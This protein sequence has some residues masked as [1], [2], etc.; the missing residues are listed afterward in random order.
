KHFPP[1][2]YHNPN[3]DEQAPPRLAQRWPFLAI[4]IVVLVQLLASA[5][6][7]QTP[8]PP[9]N[10][11]PPALM[12]GQDFQRVPEIV[13]SGNKLRGTIILSDEQE[14]MTFRVPV[15]APSDSSR[16]QCEPQ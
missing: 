14:W 12:P 1:A 13:T 8:T 10:P 6:N 2:S 7:G 15:A 5:A 11:C 9:V 16:S 3:R 4:T